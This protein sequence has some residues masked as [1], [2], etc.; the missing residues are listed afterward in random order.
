MKQTLCMLFS[1]V[2]AFAAS[3]Q[4]ITYAQH[5]APLIHYHC[6]PCHQK[7]KVA[8]MPFTT[9]EEVASYATMI[10]FVTKTKYMPPWKVVRPEHA[11]E[12]ERGLTETQIQLIQQ[13]VDEGLEKGE[14]V[15]PSS[16]KENNLSTSQA[17]KTLTKIEEL[18]IPDPDVVYAMAESFQQYGVY[19]D[20]FRVF[21]IP[22]HLTEDREVSAIAFVPGNKSIVRGCQ[23]SID[24]SSKSKPLDDWDPQYGYFTFGE[25]GFVPMESRW[26]NWHPNKTVTHF[27]E[28]T[29]KRLPKGAKLLLHIHYGPTGYPQNDSSVIQI[30]FAKQK[31]QQT[32]YTAPLIHPYNMT[33]DTFL[34]P[35]NETFRVHAKFVVPFDMLLYGLFP[36][37]HLLGRRW[38]VFTVDPANRNSEVLLE[39]ADWDFKWKQMYDF[40]TPRLL[41]KGTVVHALAA[42]DNTLNNLS[43]PSNPARETG[44]GSQMFKEFF[45]VY[46]QY[47]I[48]DQAITAFD[49]YF[50]QVNVSSP[51][52]Q[53]DIQ[54]SSP[55]KLD[56]AIV[57]FDGT[58]K[59]KL[60]QQQPFEAGRK[61]VEVSMQHLPRGNYYLELRDVVT[62]EA[63]RSLFVYLEDGM[64]K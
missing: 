43:N 52:F 13:W 33:N 21:V 55:V 37:S 32:I 3:A 26:Y 34:L 12:G 56:A 20:Q 30:K 15:Q 31:I 16:G 58:Q 41:K 47:G 25:L 29:G 11:F 60:F 57:S 19:Y 6:T 36:Q 7:G 27:P 64:F 9:Y 53:F 10:A 59:V 42:Y 4:S 44:W 1:L 54:T 61:S 63:K 2:L 40:K 5:I 62:G 23:I 14:T 35:A 8:P 28:G 18:E 46:F 22:T 48:P 24:T 50:N 45:M 38:E 49:I 39:I 51:V 17:G